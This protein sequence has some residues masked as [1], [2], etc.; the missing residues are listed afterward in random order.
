MT[1]PL[2]DLTR[3][4]KPA[5]E[6]VTSSLARPPSEIIKSRM[7]FHAIGTNYVQGGSYPRMAYTLWLP[8]TVFI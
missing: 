2:S 1:S 7:I 4:A 8:I 5:D 3:W 6:F